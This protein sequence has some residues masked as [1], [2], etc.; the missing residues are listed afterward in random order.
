MMVVNG[1]EELFSLIEG[2]LSRDDNSRHN[3]N[4][5]YSLPSLAGMLSSYVQREYYLRRVLTE[6]QRLLHEEGWWYHHQMAQLS[7]Y[8]AGFSALD[9]MKHGLQSLNPFSVRSRPPRHLRTFLDQAANFI[10]KV[11]QE[12][13]GAVALNDLTSVAAAYLWYE[14]EVLG[15][16]LKYDDVRNA[17]QS[18]IYNIN[19]DFRSGNS[20][21][22]NVTITIG[23]PSPALLDEPIP[24]NTLLRPRRFAELPKDYYDEVNEALLDVM[25]EG[26]AEG[27]PWTFPLITI[28]VTD[29][30]DWSSRV[31]ERFLELMDNFGGLYFENYLSEPFLDE[32]WRERVEGLE[33]RDPRLQ[34]SFCCR[35][36]VDLSE[37]TRVPHTGSIFGNVSGV[38]SIG[39]ITLN[40]NRL[41]YL[42]R[43]DLSSLLEH[44]DLLLEEARDALNR[45]RE[46]IMRH[47]QLYPTFFYYVDGSLRTYF[48]TISL[49]GGHEGLV[50]FGIR[51]GILSEEGL[52]L[53]RK[54]AKHILERIREFQ[55]A[56]GVA[57]NFEYAPM[58]T[59]AGYLARK[60][61][62]FVRS[63]R[64]GREPTLF[65]DIV[66]SRVS[67]WGSVPD[68]YV[69]ASEER[70][71]L[72]S[73]F[74][75]PFS[76]RSVSKLV[77]VSAH[78][79]NYATGGSVL[80]LFLGERVD[81]EVKRELVRRIFSR[82]PVKYMTITPTLTICNSCRGR[83]VGEHLKCP[84]CGSDDTT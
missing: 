48:N 22:T 38:G 82:Y 62:E 34:R 81:V 6:R 44:L 13:S 31:F 39:V 77:Y 75:P 25:A 53:A 17:F 47:R 18:F 78:T 21:F 54:V 16:E 59:A 55:E 35:F 61:L 67:A 83:Y 26:D 74:Q 2:Y 1:L 30:F 15:K 71:I 63:L 46:F 52:R 79:Q 45:K 9:I 68:I 3:A 76:E 51:E 70:P 10:L 19:L 49:G 42:H 4:L 58:E 65:R 5:I 60:D 40:F 64:E 43:G 57:W 66:R 80:H 28:Y 84:G 36:Q 11:S 72:T 50:N 24:L 69:S 37:L 33:P 41:A 73:G 8:C 12:V 20:P 29:D 32:R 14:R 56:D 27:K 7:P 23:G